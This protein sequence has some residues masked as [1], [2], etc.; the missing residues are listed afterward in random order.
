MSSLRIT[1]LFSRPSILALAC[2]LGAA[3]TGCGDDGEGSGAAGGGPSGGGGEGGAP[4][5]LP[6]LPSVEGLTALEDTN[7]DPTIVEVDLVAQP[8]SLSLVSGRPTA[9]L[10]YNGVVPGPLLH[11]R[12]GDRVIVHFTNALDEPTTIHWHGLRISDQ[13]D[14][15]PMIQNP[16]QPGETFTYDFVVPDAGTFWYHT[17]LHQI[18]QLERGLYGAIVVHEAE[19]PVFSAERI[20]VADDIRLSSANQVSTFL[21]SGPDIGM[22]RVGNTLLMNGVEAPLPV[23]IPRGAVERWR[24]V[25]ANNALSY[26][27]RF[28]GADVR[29]ISTDGGLL[30][31]SFSLA[32][33]EDQRVEIAAGQ[34]YDFEVRPQAD[35]T[36]VVM[37]ALILVADSQGNVSEEPFDLAVAAVGGEVE[38]VEPIYPVVTLPDATVAPAESLTWNLSGG[39]VAGKVEFTINGESVFVGDDHEHVIIDTFAPNVPIAITLRSTVSPA[40][41]FHVHGQFFQIIERGGQP[42]NEPGLR[43]TVHVRGAE[44]ATILS[45]F[46]NPGRWMVHCHISEHSENGMMADIVVGDASAHEH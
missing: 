32:D 41:P 13:M 6:P 28:R 9:L 33:A 3:L 27:V 4:I 12:V 43:D 34:R 37:E 39:V 46:E 10:G 36:E 14:G 8:T 26:G 44:S 45:Y 18:E 29:V 5:E 42:V 17:H 2:V 19:F 20:F 31:S 16:V 11:A 7:E 38:T 40:H 25:S 1:S 23:T 30:P 24:L 22:G 21:T 15:S 35:A